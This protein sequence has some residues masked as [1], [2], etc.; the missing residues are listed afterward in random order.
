MKFIKKD[1]LQI[2]MRKM[3]SPEADKLLLLDA[4]V[5]GKKSERILVV[6]LYYAVEQQPVLRV[7]LSES[8]WISYSLEEQKWTRKTLDKISLEC[9][10][11]SVNRRNCSVTNNAIKAIKAMFPNFLWVIDAASIDAIQRLLQRTQEAE[12][13]SAKESRAKEALHKLGPIPQISHEDL[14]ALAEKHQS[15]ANIIYWVEH[16]RNPLTNEWEP[17][18]EAYCTRCKQRTQIDFAW[19][20]GNT[21]TCPECGIEANMITPSKMKNG[22]H[23][24][25]DAIRY[26]TSGEVAFAVGYH[27][28]RD[29]HITSA[30]PRKK[31]KNYKIEDTVLGQE[32]ELYIFTPKEAFFFAKWEA[33]YMGQKYPVDDWSLKQKLRENKPYVV[34]QELT[35]DTL[36]G[37]VLE[38][39]HVWDYVS[40]MQNKEVRWMGAME[41]C[42]AYL[43]ATGLENLLHIGMLKI[44]REK[45]YGSQVLNKAAD[46]KK[47]KPSEILGLNKEEIN[48]AMENSW[49]GTALLYYKKA[50]DEGWDITEEELHVIDEIM[51]NTY[52]KQRFDFVAGKNL[53]KAIR[54]IERQSKKENLSPTGILMLWGDYM[55]DAKKLNYDLEKETLHY[56]SHLKEMHDRVA[57]VIKTLGVKAYEQAVSK[58]AK[59]LEQF[60]FSNEEYLIRPAQ[61]AKEFVEE[62]TKLDHCVAGYVQ[63]HAGGETAIF[64][65]RKLSNPEEPYF[66]LEF[67]EKR[68]TVRQNR[69]FKNCEP[70]AEVTQ[71]VRQWLKELSRRKGKKAA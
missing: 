42:A 45:A 58:R 9:I 15:K 2:A 7:F 71:F 17:Y 6:T 21:C 36:K 47:L 30:N 31:Q 56:P 54:Y 16:E 41:Y 22:W 63:D 62:G 5:H 24:K 53:K 39:S 69:G 11:D 3:P 23:D 27:I 25:L 4:F 64:F 65:I 68:Q 57:I 46:F 14:V 55:R 52:S 20:N 18:T 10:Q 37:T 35:E 51:C 43:K 59:E 8:N 12:Q 32:S 40:Q 13:Y 19:A 33:G 50:K 49:N 61:S 48:R 34:A 1:L 44:V 66:T 60:A 67:D 26:Y 38:N 29:L 28:E 70:P